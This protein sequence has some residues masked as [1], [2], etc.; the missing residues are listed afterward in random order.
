MKRA[1]SCILLILGV[2]CWSASLTYSQTSGAPT[3][4]SDP[5]YT[6]GYQAGHNDAYNRRDR[7][8]NNSPSTTEVS[9]VI[10]NT[11]SGYYQQGYTQGYY[12]G[13]IDRS[14]YEGGHYNTVDDGYKMDPYENGSQPW[15]QYLDAFKEGWNACIAGEPA[16][17]TS[18]FVESLN[19]LGT[20]AS[21]CPDFPRIQGY[22]AGYDH[23]SLHLQAANLPNP[24]GTTNA[25]TSSSGYNAGYQDGYNGNGYQNNPTASADDQ[26]NYHDGYFAGVADKGDYDAGYQ[27]GLSDHNAG[28]SSN[29]GTT[30]NTHYI[31]GYNAGYGAS[32]TTATTTL[33]ADT[34]Q[35]MQDGWTDGMN[36]TTFKDVQNDTTDSNNYKTGY[37]Q[38]YFISFLMRFFGMSF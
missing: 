31:Q 36:G 26:N 22:A 16:Q 11:S 25:N 9:G 28:N 33:P 6:S 18:T 21:N 1:I 3:S 2:F 34:M 10:I 15:Q 35:G 20:N 13:T 14:V 8:V 24:D 29:P 19:N 4:Q 27:K 38:G 12:Q 37:L 17:Y 5:N 32:T 7:A 23:A 30:T